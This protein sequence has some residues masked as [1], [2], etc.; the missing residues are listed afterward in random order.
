M[1]LGVLLA[2]G[3][4]GSVTC[5][6]LLYGE[7]HRHVYAYRCSPY[8]IG[9]HEIRAGATTGCETRLYES[10]CVSLADRLLLKEVLYVVVGH[11]LLLE[12]ISTSF[13]RLDHLDNLRV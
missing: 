6:T 11:H 13:G 8:I 1:E 3:E 5:L 9:T 4:A 7:E 10:V 12:G 2:L